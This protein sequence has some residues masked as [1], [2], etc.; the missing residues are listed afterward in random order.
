MVLTQNIDT[1][2]GHSFDLFTKSVLAFV[3]SYF[4]K[5]WLNVE[6]F[7]EES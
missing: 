3:A 7:S 4:D 1:L 5:K 6:L 2:F